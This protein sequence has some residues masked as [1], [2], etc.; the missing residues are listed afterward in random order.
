[1]ISASALRNDSFHTYITDAL[2]QC[3]SSSRFG[4]GYDIQSIDIDSFQC[5]G[6]EANISLCQRRAG[7]Q[8]EHNDDASVICS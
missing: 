7:D 1:M 5:S 8:C 2:A 6:N 4:P 3:C